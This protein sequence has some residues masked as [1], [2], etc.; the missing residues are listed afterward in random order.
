MTFAAP[1][2][3]ALAVLIPV[4]V[5]GLGLLDELRRRALVKRL[6][7]APQVRRM[8]ASA[9]AWRR[10]LKRAL[11][12]LGLAAIAAAAARPQVPGT[13]TASKEGLDLV[14]ALDVSK[15]MLVDDVGDTRLARAR[16][17]ID[18]LVPRLV[19]DRVGAV[20][21][22]NAAAHFP[23][24]D[25]KEVALQFLHDL[26]PADLPGGSS[27]GEALRTGMCMLRPDGIDAWSNPCQAADAR[28]GHGGD[29]LPGEPDDTPR[30]ESVEETSER[31]KVILLVTDG[32]D[33]LDER[34]REA[35][36][37]EADSANKLGIT[38]LLIGVG[39]PAGGDVPEIDDRG[40]V[41]GKK[42]DEYGRPVHSALEATMLRALAELLG[43][44]D[45]FFEL[46]TDGL[47]PQRVVDALAALTRGALDKK[48][49]RAMDE[50]YAILLFPGFMLLVIEACI[51]N[52]RRVKFPEGNP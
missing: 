1:D 43:A 5:I 18:Q 23:L 49:G 45:R 24:T 34:G 9:S 11:L 52:R 31:S 30:I 44:P 28:R 16:A 15:S 27:L 47:D 37:R 22:A 29:P 46:G 50:W 19:N 40:V 26:G 13:R 4:V 41:S 2:F 3:L 7:A 38:V 8:M 12:A 17:F 14:I 25:D 51:G 39:T 36:A 48:E 20:V 10:W 33:G 42:L 21:F 35:L 6:G 32:A